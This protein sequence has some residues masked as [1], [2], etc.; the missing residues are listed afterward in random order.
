MFSPAFFSSSS[1]SVVSSWKCPYLVTRALCLIRETFPPILTIF[2]T[3]RGIVFAAQA[4]AFCGREFRF[5]LRNAGGFIGA[6]IV[7]GDRALC[8]T[9][10]TFHQAGG[11]SC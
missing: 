2:C 11:V 1:S 6:G 4:G 3:V 7:L 8:P 5:A 10:E 9:S